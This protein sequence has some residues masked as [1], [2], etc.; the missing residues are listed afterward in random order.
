MPSI[1]SRRLVIDASI[2]RAAGGIEATFPTSKHCRDFLKATLTICHRMVMT[3]EIEDEWKAHQ[4]KFARKWR[5][6]MEGKKKICR[7]T[8]TVNEELRTKLA[9][10][11]VSRTA[12]AAMLKDIHL[13]EAALATD[14]IVV[15]LDETVRNFFNASAASLGDLK[16]VLWLNPDK[17]EEESIAWL[18]NGAKPEKNRRIGFR[19]NNQ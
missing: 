19:I 18:E 2:A 1:I 14:K 5:R 3:P 17:E 4:S 10:I 8:N 7:P 13:I 11:S 16:N 9:R 12:E 15:S 6:Y